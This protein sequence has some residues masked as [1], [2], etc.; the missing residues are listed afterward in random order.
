MRLFMRGR[1]SAI[2]QGCVGAARRHTAASDAAAAQADVTTHA[3]TTA[4]VRQ[5][6]N[7]NNHR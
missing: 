3:G 6:Y 7:Q 2:G 5:G 4:A 1:S